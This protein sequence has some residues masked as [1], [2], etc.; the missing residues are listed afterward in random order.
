MECPR[1]EEA[2]GKGA[3]QTAR[4]RELKLVRGGAESRPVPAAGDDAS[5]RRALARDVDGAFERLV[6]AYQDRLYSF[7][8][9]LCGNAADAEDVAQDAFVRAYRALKTYA[10]EKIE[11]LALRPWLYRIA[12]NVARNRFRRKRHPTVPLGDG[13]GRLLHDPQDDPASRPDSRLEKAREREDLATLVAGLPDRYRSAL[14]LRYVEGLKLEEVAAVLKQ[15]LGTTKSNV[16]R[17][18]NALRVAITQSR[19]RVEVRA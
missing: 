4:G 12:L 2:A 18:I 13:D 15:P 10:A 6:R 14:I 16:H 1:S 7:A 11:G 8:H 3:P 19:R 5:L 17:A 9:R